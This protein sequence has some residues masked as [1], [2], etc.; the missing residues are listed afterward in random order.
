MTRRLL[1]L[2]TALTAL[3]AGLATADVVDLAPSKDNTLYQHPDGNL[4]NGAGEVMFAGRNNTVPGENLR[5]ALIAFDLSSIPSGSIVTNATLRLRCS[6]VP[7]VWSPTVQSLHRVRADW[8]EGASNAGSP[9]GS[10]ILAEPGDATWS[11]R[12]FPATPWANLGG[13]FV[14]SFSAAQTID[15][16]GDY[17]WGSTAE[18]VGDVQ[19]WVLKPGASFGWI[20]IGNEA[21][22]QSSR[23]FD[24]KENTNPAVRP[25]LHV[26]YTPGVAGV[27]DPASGGRLLRIRGVHPNPV[28]LES[29]VAFSLPTDQP[30]WLAIVDLSG[31]RIA[32][33]ALRLGAGNHV[34][35]LRDLA[36]APAGIYWVVLTQAEHS[37]A[38]KIAVI[39]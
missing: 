26:E 4:S 7:L 3:A 19:L 5:R 27:D 20:L 17:T 34:V 23:R 8:G 36:R 35:E 2:V 1:L 21:T 37:A 18:M 30:A 15:S 39:R 10:G 25:L 6:Q 22:A 12:F 28:V 38:A 33:R 24:T 9:G 16:V 13:D 14:A 29:S 11:Q 31:R 32:E